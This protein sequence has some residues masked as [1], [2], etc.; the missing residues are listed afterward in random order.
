[1]VMAVREC[2]DYKCNCP[3]QYALYEVDD[4]GS[5]SHIET[6]VNSAFI[7]ST[8]G[9][10]G[11]G[12]LSS[13]ANGGSSTVKLLVNNMETDLPQGSTLGIIADAKSFSTSDGT[14]IVTA[15]AISNS[16]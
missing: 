10:E 4:N 9:Y 15:G 5:T 16:N 6:D 13:C 8:E 11:T 14:Y 1:S 2:S 12:V 3:M 7:F